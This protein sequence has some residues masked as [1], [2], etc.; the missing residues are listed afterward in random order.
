MRVLIC[1]RFGIFNCFFKYGYTNESWKQES[2]LNFEGNPPNL[3][4]TITSIFDA[5]T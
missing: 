4:L 5:I 2:S 1:P 3:N